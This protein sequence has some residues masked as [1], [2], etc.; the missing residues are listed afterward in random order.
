ML[1]V[2]N[3]VSGV[4][5]AIECIPFKK[6]IT[7]R[8]QSLLGELVG[9]SSNASFF[10]PIACGDM[11]E[12]VGDVPAAIMSYAESLQYGLN[13]RNL[14]EPTE[15]DSTMD[16]AIK[17]IA[18]LVRGHIKFARSIAAPVVSEFG[19]LLTER[20]S[21]AVVSTA[22]DFK[23]VEAG[24]PIFMESERFQN[25]ILFFG[26]KIAPVP[27]KQIL[28]KEQTYE[29]ILELIKT[30]DNKL[31]T[32][33]IAWLAEFDHTEVINMFNQL[34]GYN[35][36]R[37]IPY[38]KIEQSS[39]FDT[40]KY[41]GFVYLV[42]RKG[43]MDPRE[44]TLGI[45][46][47]EFNI[48]CAGLRDWAAGALKRA[49][50]RLDLYDR[51]GTLILHTDARSKTV[52]V[53]NRNYVKFLEN[54]SVEEVL[55]TLL[56]G[57]SILTLKDIEANRE[58]LLQTWKSYHSLS[59]AE[60]QLKKFEL[61]KEI[62]KTSY[63]GIKHEFEPAEMEYIQATPSFM[64]ETEKRVDAFINTLTIKD[65]DDVY[66]VALRLVCRVRF[67]YTSAEEILSN[68]DMVMKASGDK[69]EPREAGLIATIQ[70]VAKFLAT[71][72]VVR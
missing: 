65:M 16:T 62:L 8:P 21:N 20:L 54:G 19:N 50:S 24:A 31:D 49:L 63:F 30:G 61:F 22:M 43:Y 5:L 55:A 64:N 23:V 4:P 3:V 34:F 15:H 47:S 56:V 37:A 10:M 58:K 68:I 38:N 27:L 35:D 25:E 28:F 69:L 26:D 44:G 46:V 1:R 17:K 53:Y 12:T 42:A 52:T 9:I 59:V 36:N 33:I 13:A 57:G 7:A 70:Y 40:I 6:K 60:E 67:Y 18:E 29:Q 51:V 11:T 66:G 41:L 48:Q 14:N 71:Q 39:L 2:N 45:Q 72:I 32:L